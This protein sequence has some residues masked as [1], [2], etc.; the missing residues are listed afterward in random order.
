MHDG[1]ADHRDFEDVAALG[2]CGAGDFADQRIDGGAHAPRQFR[3]AAR[4]HHHVRD[5]AHQIFAKANLRVHQSGRGEDLAV[6]EIAE[7]RGDRRRTDVEGDA[8]SP[9]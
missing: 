5:A 9:S 7:M 3:I 1:I 6:H 2:V 8:Q 4:I